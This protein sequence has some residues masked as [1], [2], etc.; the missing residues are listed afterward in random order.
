[1]NKTGTLQG[2]HKDLEVYPFPADF[3]NG[4]AATLLIC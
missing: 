4:E 1:M 2:N 3:Q